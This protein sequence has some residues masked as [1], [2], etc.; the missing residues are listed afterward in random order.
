MVK[1]HSSYSINVN[2]LCQRAPPSTIKFFLKS[3]LSCR[4]VASSLESN[5][6]LPFKTFMY[7]ALYNLQNAFLSIISFESH[8]QGDT[9]A[10]LFLS[11]R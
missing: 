8:N 1:A 4:I 3:G 11:Q 5:K 9:Q 7:I 2:S 6:S 10:I